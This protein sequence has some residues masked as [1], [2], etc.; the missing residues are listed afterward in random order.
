MPSANVV[1]FDAARVEP[2]HSGSGTAPAWQ[3]SL[4]HDLGRLRSS[5]RR[6]IA[7]LDAVRRLTPPAEPGLAP[8]WQSYVDLQVATEKSEAVVAAVGDNL[9]EAQALLDGSA[10]ARAA[11]RL[12]RAGSA[13]EA[14]LGCLHRAREGMFLV[15]DDA[16]VRAQLPTLRAG[17]ATIIGSDD[18]RTEGY[19]RYL[20]D[21]SQAT[22]QAPR[23]TQTVPG[24]AV[25]P[26]P[27]TTFDQATREQL[28]AIQAAVDDSRMAAQI[29]VRG[30]RNALVIAVAVLGAVALTF[31]G[32]AALADPGMAVIRADG[33]GT[34]VGALAGNLSGVE[35]W[36]ALGSLVAVIAGLWRLRS[37]RQPS[38]L[39]L[40]Q[41]ALKVPA[42]ALTAL[43]GVLL[44]QGGIVVQLTAV[45]AR[46]VPAYAIL[47][48]FA[49][50]ALTRFV[51]GKAAQ[52]LDDA[53]PLSDRPS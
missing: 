4:R 41:L 6:V 28:R 39:Q 46:Q 38:G 32:I 36:G 31:P 40:A 30:Y 18:P 34:P 43:F 15:E 22:G 5:R 7:G 10:M 13:F 11:N 14:V 20:D 47:F 1:P 49:Q 21:L 24:S 45:Q 37:S 29:A 12:L 33:A 2:D 8:S 42:G 9:A 26:P 51:D 25:V 17:V 44:M 53:K 16:W 19:V 23:L 52:L 27:M 50:E 35:I 48:G 3:T